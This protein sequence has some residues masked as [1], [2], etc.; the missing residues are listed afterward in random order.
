MGDKLSGKQPDR[1][2][3]G[4]EENF[5]SQ[6]ADNYLGNPQVVNRI[7]AGYIAE[8]HKWARLRSTGIMTAEEM[9]EQVRKRGKEFSLIFS[10]Q[11]PNY[12]PI[13]GWNHKEVG[14]RNYMMI[15]LGHYW[16]EARSA[17]DNDPLGVT[18]NWLLWAVV[19]SLKMK[20]KDESEK[21][22]SDFIKTLIQMLTGTIKRRGK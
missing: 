9:N 19:E 21:W 10:G 16:R 17:W 4:A 2:N 14:L 3:D 20:D 15:D 18:Y 6:M 5:A 12:I 7:L 13:A 8:M 11:D 1:F 22:L